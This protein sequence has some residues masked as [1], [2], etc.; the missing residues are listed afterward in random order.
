M[1]QK[2][3][4]KK[5]ITITPLGRYGGKKKMGDNDQDSLNE[6]LKIFK[7]VIDTHKTFKAT[8]KEILDEHRALTKSTSNAKKNV[9]TLM[10]Q[11]NIHVLDLDDIQ[12]ELKQRSSLKH[13][14]ELLNEILQDDLKFEN[15]MEKINSLSNAIVTRNKK[16]KS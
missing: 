13:D 4:K 1:K 9:M 2:N 12:I 16:R 5:Y 7:E 3:Q 10:Q 14:P 8:N 6:A 11:Q 15:Y